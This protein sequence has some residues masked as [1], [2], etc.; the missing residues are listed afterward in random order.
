MEEERRADQLELNTVKDQM[1]QFRTEYVQYKAEAQRL[2][3]ALTNTEEYLG[4]QV[5]MLNEKDKDQVMKIEELEAMNNDMG[6]QHREAVIELQRLDRDRRQLMQLNE[7]FNMQTNELQ[8]REMQYQDATRMYN[9][10]LE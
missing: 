6:Q 2:Q 3:Q 4:G 9:E 5:R 8:R 1:I 7:Q 10:R